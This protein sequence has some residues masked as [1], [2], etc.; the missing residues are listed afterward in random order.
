M[1]HH[2]SW[3]SEGAPG[4]TDCGVLVV[5]IESLLVVQKVVLVRSVFKSSCRKAHEHEYVIPNLG[6]GATLIL[7]A[8]GYQ[9]ASPFENEVHLSSSTACQH[10][11]TR[12][13]D[14]N[15]R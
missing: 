11:H 8:R 12:S 2:G 13:V 10:V 7:Q 6:D 4:R 5:H 15:S 9:G 14:L 3:P 1:Q